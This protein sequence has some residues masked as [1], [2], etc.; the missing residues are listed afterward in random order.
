MRYGSRKFLM[1][2]A[3]LGVSSWL[4]YIGAIDTAGWSTVVLGTVGVYM[5]ANVYQKKVPA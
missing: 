1:A 5:A 2:V 4:V 3:S